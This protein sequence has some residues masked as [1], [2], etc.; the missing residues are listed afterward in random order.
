MPAVIQTGKRT[1]EV[2]FLALKQQ[3]RPWYRRWRAVDP[4]T[5]ELDPKLVLD[6]LTEVMK[7]C[8]MADSDG[9]LV[10]NEFL[11]FLTPDDHDDFAYLGRRLEAQ[12]GEHLG[13]VA[14]RLRAK[15]IGDFVLRLVSDEGEEVL[16]HHGIVHT[17]CKDNP[18]LDLADP[19]DGEYT[20]RARQRPL[21][22]PP[23]T[24][25]APSA[26]AV[27]TAPS[28]IPEGPLPGLVL[29]TED[30]QH[31]FA[32]GKGV[33]WTVGREHTPPPSA[34]HVGIP[35]DTTTVSRQA[36]RIEVLETGAMITRPEHDT[37]NALQVNGEMVAKG[38]Q[39][40][41]DRFPAEILLTR[42]VR[43]ILDVI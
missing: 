28:V 2:D 38:R 13:K 23:A 17:A 32:L 40:H 43:L 14:R 27:A 24:P 6:A 21:A 36:F 37:A 5:L 8:D 10:W 39:M 35:V 26:P 4:E 31:S 9:R 41:V 19:L 20:V 34:N 42:H 18:D 7:H 3:T 30:R 29:H 25:P 33:L 11:I 15:P 1:F 16:P 12:C 22:P